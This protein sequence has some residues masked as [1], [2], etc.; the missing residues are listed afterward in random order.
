MAAMY[1]RGEA[2][3]WY[4]GVRSTC[5][6]F[7]D[8]KAGLNVRFGET[9]AALMARVQNCK[10]SK[11]TSV[12]RYVDSLRMLFAKTAYPSSGQCTLFVNGLNSKFQDRVKL[13]RPKTLT[14]AIEAAT[15]F[16]DMDIGSS[17]DRAI[18]V[19][20]RRKEEPESD[21][22]K[23]TKEMSKLVM[24]THSSRP[25]ARTQNWDAQECFKCGKMGHIARDCSRPR[26]SKSAH[27]VGKYQRDAYGQEQGGYYDRDLRASQHSRNRTDYYAQTHLLETVPAGSGAYFDY[28]AA[29]RVPTTFG[30]QV[31]AAGGRPDRLPRNRVPF[32]PDAIRQRRATEAGSGAP[33]PTSNPRI[34][35]GAPARPG[36]ATARGVRA[37]MPYIPSRGQSEFDIVAQLGVTK[38]NIDMKSYLREA[39]GARRSLRAFM[40]SVDRQDGAPGPSAPPQLHS[41][42]AGPPAAPPMP[43][44]TGPVP[45]ESTFDT[46][47]AYHANS[48]PPRYLNT[49]VKAPVAVCGSIFEAIIDTGASDTVVSHAVIRRLGL[50]DQMVPSQV[51]YLTA[52]GKSESPMGMMRDLPLRIGSLELDLDVM[53][54]PANSYNLL[55]GNDLL[56]MAS[57]DIMLSNNILRL[58]IEI[59]MR[60]FLLMK[61]LVQGA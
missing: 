25:P 5:T 47:A 36:Q 28:A 15:D 26:Q 32:S 54:T 22:A 27:H 9:E 44:G 29:D 14:E 61:H 10:Q 6:T 55:I 37:S 58:R 4:V 18:G 16:E 52:A 56:R 46:E 21:I 51:T 43:P 7:A 50:M 39:P 3:E 1:L 20:A 12:W 40:D 53:V 57:A 2:M 17:P 45:M 48:N 31:Y 41:R 35:P 11:D 60:S 13:G 59:S 42:P 34:N 49:V 38:L 23:L 8:F 19:E 24:Q 33:N 30:A